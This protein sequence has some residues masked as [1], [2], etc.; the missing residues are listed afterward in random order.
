MMSVVRYRAS[1]GANHTFP[2]SE[3]MSLGL[4][5]QSR[6]VCEFHWSLRG[7]TGMLDPWVFSWC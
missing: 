7:L 6:C 4:H 3:G 1:L 2:R 5:G